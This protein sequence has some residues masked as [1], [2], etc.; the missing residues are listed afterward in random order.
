[1]KHTVTSFFVDPA[2][3]QRDFH[4]IWDFHLL[5]W[6]VCLPLIYRP[7]PAGKK[8]EHIVMNPGGLGVGGLH[9]LILCYCLVSYNMRIR[10]FFLAGIW[11]SGGKYFWLLRKINKAQWSRYGVLV[12]IS[13]PHFS[14]FISTL[15]AEML[16]RVRPPQS[17]PLS[18]GKLRPPG[19]FI[20][21]IFFT[22]QRQTEAIVLFLTQ[23][24]L[25][26]RLPCPA[27]A[28]CWSS[29]VYNPYPGIVPTAPASKVP[30]SRV[31]AQVRSWEAIAGIVFKFLYISLF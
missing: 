6:H 1:M 25:S 22:P 7:L 30:P 13:P 10:V 14:N 24:S 21:F 17:G 16:L 4:D 2:P 19:S 28:R 12:L 9:V 5:S 11:I 27:A 20:G 26:F 15:F 8:K 3:L 18:K 23:H 31:M 29:E